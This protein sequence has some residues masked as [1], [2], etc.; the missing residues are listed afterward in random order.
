[1]QHIQFAS[2]ADAMLIAPCTM[3]MLG[4]LASG[5]TDNSVTLVCAAINREHTPVLVAPAMNA[6]MLNQPAT[7]RNIN[8]LHEDGYTILNS[9]DGWQACGAVGKGRM[10]EPEAL[11]CALT[12]LFIK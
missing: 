5:I 1:P 2:N 3:N 12:S 10:L 9:D 4:K 11:F 8:T 7:Q 6:T